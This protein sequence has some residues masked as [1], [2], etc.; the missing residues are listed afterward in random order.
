MGVPH[1]PFEP[2]AYLRSGRAAAAERVLGATIQSMA[3]D[4]RSDSSRATAARGLARHIDVFFEDPAL[5]PLVIIFVVHAALAGALV[6]LA[7]LRAGSPP[8]LAL[9]AI[10]LV[11]SVNTIWRARQRRRVTKWIG[12]LW[13]LSALT[14]AVSSYLGLL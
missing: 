5:W 7:A 8:A 14:A 13:A 3:D 2:R 6:L 12:M 10:L 11:L 4:A 1:H 9:L